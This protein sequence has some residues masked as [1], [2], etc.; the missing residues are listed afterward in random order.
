M[1][2][3]NIYHDGQQNNGLITKI[4][5]GPGWTFCH[6]ITFGYPIEPTDEQINNYRTFFISLG[7]V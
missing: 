1:T 6:S 4:W 5:G 7:N 2:T 3:C